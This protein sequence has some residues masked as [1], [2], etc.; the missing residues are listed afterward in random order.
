MEHKYELED[1]RQ[2]QALPLECKLSM[3]TIRIRD[4]IR[5]FGINGVYVSFSGGKDSTVLLDIVR[6]VQPN[7]QAVFIDTGLEYP[8]IRDFVK[9]ID[10]VVWLKPK[11]N[12][13]KV[14]QTYGYPLFSKN[15][16]HN[17]SVAKRNPNGNVKKNVFSP[18]KQ[19]PYAM[20][21]WSFMLD[22]NAPNISEKCCDIMKKAPAHQY[23][24]ETGRVPF[25][26][27]LAEES[28]FRLDNWLKYGCN[29]FELKKPSSQPLSF[30]TEQDILQYISENQLPYSKAYG[31]IKKDCQGRFYT[32]G[33]NRTGCMFCGFGLHLEKEPNRLQRDKNMYPNIYQY[34]MKSINDGGLGLKQVLDWVN[35]NSELYIPY[36]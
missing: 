4:W 7:T 27:T 19:G 3:S 36:E 17:V 30:W 31:E 23:Q 16:A 8:E 1:L 6:K 21:K 28:R 25:I 22:E 15:V 34:E 33:A 5:E 9:T 10:N 11:M 14:I 24:K 29:A 32:T 18:D 20:Y 13:R 12:F 2:R 35:K 26:G